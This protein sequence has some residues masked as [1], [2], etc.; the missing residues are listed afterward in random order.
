[1]RTGRDWRYLRRVP[2]KLYELIRLSRSQIYGVESA[3]LLS[4]VKKSNRHQI[5]SIL[6]FDFNGCWGAW[7][8]MKIGEPI[9]NHN[10]L[11]IIAGVFPV[12]CNIAAYA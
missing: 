9:L 10:H 4:T 3:M 7:L 2:I 5:Q 6:N 8:V 1:M 12:T 11:V